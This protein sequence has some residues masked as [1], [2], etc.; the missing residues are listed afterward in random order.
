MYLLSTTQNKLFG[1]QHNASVFTDATKL[2]LEF[3]SLHRTTWIF[4]REVLKEQLTHIPPPALCCIQNNLPRWSSKVRPSDQNTQG[5][6]K[7]SHMYSDTFFF[8]CALWHLALHYSSLS[9]LQDVI[10]SLW[11]PSMQICPRRQPFR[12]HE[13]CLELRFWN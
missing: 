7:Q 2:F 9:H 10:T 8:S 1:N 11:S 5:K 3:F 4:K 12:L 13:L 6:T